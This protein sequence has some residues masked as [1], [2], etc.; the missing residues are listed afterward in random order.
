MRRSD[1]LIY[2]NCGGMFSDAILELI[3]NFFRKMQE[4]RV[5]V[6]IS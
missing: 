6:T 2:Y 4:T 1:R 5:K 3:S